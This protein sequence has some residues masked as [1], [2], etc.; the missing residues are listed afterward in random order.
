MKPIEL[1][2]KMFQKRAEGLAVNT[3]RRSFIGKLGIILVGAAAVPLLPVARYNRAHAADGDDAWDPSQVTNPDDW[4]NPET[5]G[6]WANCATDGWM[7]GC[8]GGSINSCPP[9]STPSPV[10]WIGTCKN[11]ANN[12]SYIVSYEDCC[13]TINCNRCW[14][15]RDEGDTPRYRPSKSN[16]IV[17]CF[18]GVAATYHCTTARILSEVAES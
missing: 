4:N 8:C 2:D 3:S 14:C 5:C 10:T 17:W 18:G 15:N 13:G 7:C 9:G 16:A 1:L 6:Y 12:K 11:P